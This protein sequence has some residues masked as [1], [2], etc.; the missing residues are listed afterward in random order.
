MRFYFSLRM[1][2][3]ITWDSPIARLT[4]NR[5]TRAQDVPHAILIVRTTIIPC[6][7][8]SHLCI[9]RKM[10][11]GETNI[12]GWLASVQQVGDHFSLILSNFLS[13]SKRRNQTLFEKEV[14]W[15]NISHKLR[16]FNYLLFQTDWYRLT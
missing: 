15:Q 10:K 1:T 8:L 4:G 2:V 16:N 14:I 6:G 7:H 9:K 3:R 5:L 11:K 13:V 12:I